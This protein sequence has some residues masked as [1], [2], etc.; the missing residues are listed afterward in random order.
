MSVKGR[1]LNTQS[2]LSTAE[3]KVATFILNNPEKTI[4]MTAAQLAK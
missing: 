2:E 1:I 3:S 4:Q